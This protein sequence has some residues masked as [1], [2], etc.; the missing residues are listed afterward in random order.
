MTGWIDEA[1]LRMCAA[2]SLMGVDVASLVVGLVS[3]VASLIAIILA[4]V[5]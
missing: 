5:A 4:L 3:A 2:G 1:D